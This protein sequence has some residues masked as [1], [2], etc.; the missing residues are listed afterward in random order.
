MTKPIAQPA[1]H[2]WSRA[3]FGAEL[4]RLTPHNDRGTSAGKKPVLRDWQS[5][6]VTA[7]DIDSWAREGGNVGLRTRLYPAIDIDVDDPAIADACERVATEVLGA[8]ARRTR[9]NSARRALLYRLKGDPMPKTALRIQIPDGTL[10]KVE[11]LGDGQQLAVA[12]IHPSGAP[13][14]WPLG[15][16]LA[17]SLAVLSSEG[18][19]RYLSTLADALRA[20]GCTVGAPPVVRTVPAAVSA[21]SSGA[22]TWEQDLPVTEEALRRIDPDC[23]YDDWIRVGMALHAKDSGPNGLDAWDSWSSGGDKY[24]GREKLESKWST[25]RSG[26][27]TGYG[28]LLSLAGVS[29]SVRAL[30]GGR[31]RGPAALD[32]Q[33]DTE[34]WIPHEGPATASEPEAIPEVSPPTEWL[35]APHEDRST[36]SSLEE[37][38]L[39]YF[40][41]DEG[42][43]HFVATERRAGPRTRR[44]IVRY[45]FAEFKSRFANKSIWLKYSEKPVN[46]AKTWL[47]WENRRQ[48]LGG[49]VFDPAGQVGGDAY[50][51]WRGWPIQPAPGS[52]SILQDHLY[53]VLCSK[54]DD[55][56]RYV[57]G[58]LAQMVQRPTE[59][60][61]VALVFRGVEGSG[62]SLFGD[63]L[64]R[65]FGQH[66]LAVATPRAVTGNFN[67][68]LRDLVLLV[69]NEAVFAGDRAS[70]GVLKSLLTDETIFLEQ[71]GIDGFEV[72]NMLHVFMTT[73]AEWAV[74]VTLTD[75]RFAVFD[76]PGKRTP[77]YYARLAGAVDNNAAIA[78]MLHD[79]L[80]HELADYEPQGIPRTD[81][82]QDQAL[83]SLEGPAAWIVHVLTTG[84]LG[85][86]RTDDWQ[87]HIST[88]DLQTSVET[89]ARNGRHRQDVTPI[90]L[91]R[92]LARFFRPRK[93]FTRGTQTRGWAIGPLEDARKAVADGLRLPVSAFGSDE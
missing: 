53:E 85:L 47:T 34:V 29:G 30:T 88:Q 59:P 71:K 63:A 73:N 92:F 87:E 17:A 61:R 52:W 79:L 11:V 56:Y 16:P 1:F 51:L 77:A 75:R 8:T 24:C 27:G 7:A 83:R 60:G 31:S 48:Y 54:D 25:F 40:V 49:V 2:V 21:P 42:G 72:R 13:N 65:M 55:H 50:N 80:S 45:T 62:K 66:A 33:P 41:I 90:A 82:R 93:L 20:L 43:H 74:P 67:A 76:V 14:E 38:N 4:V 64:R 84:S 57:F 5:R 69:A 10:A 68:H 23:S 19:D 39:Q 28:S 78:A 37:V 86:S 32:P 15:Q 46:L 18:R 9:S 22:R 44:V 70:F 81:A 36:P 26:S 35:D 3:G 58:W 91:G 12:G 6:A 89:W